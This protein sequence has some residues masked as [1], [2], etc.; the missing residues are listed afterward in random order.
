MN[1]SST[2]Q[3]HCRVKTSR[4]R[5]KDQASHTYYSITQVE[6]RHPHLL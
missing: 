4:V 5:I 6:L 1:P 3:N 2:H